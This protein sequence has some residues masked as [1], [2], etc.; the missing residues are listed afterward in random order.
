MY[1]I[2]AVVSLTVNCFYSMRIACAASVSP[3]IRDASA[4]S[5]AVL[6]TAFFLVTELTNS[7]LEKFLKFLRN[8]RLHD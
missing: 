7:G 2:N 3:P 6:T 4:R 5:N 8:I 1:F